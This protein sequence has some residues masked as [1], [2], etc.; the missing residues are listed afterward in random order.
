MI[1]GERI[2]GIAFLIGEHDILAG[3]K[4]FGVG[5]IDCSFFGFA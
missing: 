4:A 3:R 2:V 1:S 5:I